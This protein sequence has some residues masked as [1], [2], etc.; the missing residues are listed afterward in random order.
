MYKGE[1]AVNTS[2]RQSQFDILNRLYE[3]KCKQIEHALQQGKSL[4]SQVLEA[5][6][7]AIS[8]AIKSVR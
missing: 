5:E 4:R 8:N 6:A 3:M 2:M 1:T 7:Q